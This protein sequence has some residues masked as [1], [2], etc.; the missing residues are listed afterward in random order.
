AGHMRGLG[1]GLAIAGVI[2]HQH[3]LLMGG[4]GPVAKE[5]IE[6]TRVHRVGVPGGLRQ[7]ELQTLYGRCLGPDDG[8]RADQGREGLM[9]LAGHEQPRQVLAEAAPLRQTIEQVVEVGRVVLQWPRGGW[10]GDPVRHASTSLLI[11]SCHRRRPQ[12]STANQASFAWAAFNW[13]SPLPNPV[14]V[15]EAI[16]DRNG[17]G[18]SLGLAAFSNIG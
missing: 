15:V 6:P 3:A 13:T 11:P 16:G 7:E 2:E 4:R 9:P 1:P 5:E 18:P 14:I 10:T 12:Q 17:A 8:L